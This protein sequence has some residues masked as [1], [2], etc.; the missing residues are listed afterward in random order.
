MENA[1][2]EA[3]CIEATEFPDLSSRYR[4]YAV[5]KTVINGAGAIEGSLP[6]PFFLEEVL[7]TLPAPEPDATPDTALP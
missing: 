5:P 6:E 2:I 3:D 7:K 4:V 1:L